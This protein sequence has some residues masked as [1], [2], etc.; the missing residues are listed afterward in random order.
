MVKLEFSRREHRLS[1]QVDGVLGPQ[2]WVIVHHALNFDRFR[3][4]F[5]G[6]LVDLKLFRL[7]IS[8]EQEPATG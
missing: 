2:I 3:V 8:G 1:A 6:Y 5:S 7:E 4:D